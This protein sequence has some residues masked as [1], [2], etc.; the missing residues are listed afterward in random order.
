MVRNMQ[1]ICIPPQPGRG[2][3]CLL[4]S[5]LSILEIIATDVDHP[6]VPNHQLAKEDPEMG[7][8]YKQKSVAE[9]NSVDI[10]WDLLVSTLSSYSY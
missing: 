5:A 10:A 7:E 4:T 3:R 1:R 9:Q 2:V 6:G 8:K